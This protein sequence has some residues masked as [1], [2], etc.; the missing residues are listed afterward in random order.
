MFNNSSLSFVELEMMA[1]GFL[2]FG[3]ELQDTDFSRLAEAIG[4]LGLRAEKPEQV[5]PMLIKALEH[6]GPA[7]VDIAV[8]R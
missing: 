1:A 2:T 4:L 8:N 3:T 5:K 7:L 6:Q